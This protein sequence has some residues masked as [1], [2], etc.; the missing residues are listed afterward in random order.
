M[1][2]TIEVEASENC[3]EW[4]MQVFDALEE[5]WRIAWAKAYRPGVGDI[6]CRVSGWSSEGGGTPCDAYCAKVSDSGSGFACLVYG[7]DRGIRL[8]PASLDEQWSPHSVNQWGETHLLLGD[9]SDVAA[10]GEARR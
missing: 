10:E 2:I 7:G 4:P 6:W 5:P 8:M 9:R 3:M 1:I